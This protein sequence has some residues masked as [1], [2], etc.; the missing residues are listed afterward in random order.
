MGGIGL[1]GDTEIVAVSSRKISDPVEA[2][3]ALGVEPND[4]FRLMEDPSQKSFRDFGAFDGVALHGLF[5]I[6]ISG[7]IC[8]R[9]TGQT[10]L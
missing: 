3:S 4:R 6:D 1:D 2:L 10:P 8:A 9:Y 7:T 5:L